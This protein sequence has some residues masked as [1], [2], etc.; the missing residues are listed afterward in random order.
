MIIF[1]TLITLLVFFVIL[2]L[3]ILRHQALDIRKKSMKLQEILWERRHRIPL[4]LEILEHGGIKDVPRSEI[5]ELR[6]KVSSGAYTIEEKI[7]LEKKLSDLCALILRKGI[8]NHNVKRKVLFLALKREFAELLEGIRIAFNDYNFSLQ[9]WASYTR[10][11]KNKK[12]PL[13]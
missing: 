6:A 1:W 3:L 12:L 9:K 13:I 5:I 8:E 7:L 11:Q 10:W 4:L 2:C